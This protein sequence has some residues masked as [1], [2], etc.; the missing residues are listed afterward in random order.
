[1]GGS[2]SK[3]GVLCSKG[4]CCHF[5]F[6]KMPLAADPCPTEVGGGGA[7]S[8]QNIGLKVTALV[9]LPYGLAYL[10]ICLLLW[11]TNAHRNC[12]FNI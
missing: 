9:L 10:F 3:G 4:K 5:N 12:N 2:L 1:M 6:P 11:G 7:G 8:L